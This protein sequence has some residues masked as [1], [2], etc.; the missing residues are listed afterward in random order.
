MCAVASAT[1]TYYLKELKVLIDNFDVQ[2]ASCDYI[3]CHQRMVS[4]AYVLLNF[5]SCIY[6]FS[7]CPSS[8][9][10]FVNVFT[11]TQS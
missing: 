6:Y 2:L 5:E 11:Q 3:S 1:D 9:V 7:G 4:E 8:Q 10:K